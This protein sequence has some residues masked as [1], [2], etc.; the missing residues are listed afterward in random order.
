MADIQDELL[1]T[2]GSLVEKTGGKPLLF[3]LD[4]TNADR[5][6]EVARNFLEEVGGIDLVINNAGI[7]V[8]GLMEDVSVEDWDQ[9][10]AIN[11]MGVVHGCRVFIP[12]MK[13]AGAG[14]IINIAS[15]AAVAAGPRM[16]PYNATKAA[17]LALTETLYGELSDAGIQTSVVMP[18][19]F[20]TN[21]G[22][23]QLGSE[24]DRSDYRVFAQTFE[25]YPTGGC[26]TGFG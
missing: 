7:A 16:A 9:I 4:V 22:K 10:V 11:L 17:V 14:H 1:Q 20:K 18:T 15:A 13:Q 19:F 24:A 3:E 12:S 5:F 26:R 25:V 6:E 8:A 21:I 2:A 23:A